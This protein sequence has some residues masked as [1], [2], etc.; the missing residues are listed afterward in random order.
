MLP[1]TSPEAITPL[2]KKS[3]ISA[4]TESESSQISA[5]DSKVSW[6]STQS[7]VV[8]VPVSVPSSSRDS[9]STT[10]RSQSWVSLSTHHH[11]F[12]PPSL[13]HTTQC[14]QLTHCWNTPMSQSCSTTKQSTISAEET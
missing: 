8:L 5:L 2:V 3:L 9:P 1:T 10:V 14:S 6:S 12:Q 13:N 4:S 11:R 7:V